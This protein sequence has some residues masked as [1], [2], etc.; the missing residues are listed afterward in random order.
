VIC[1]AEGRVVAESD[2]R[3]LSAEHFFKSRAEMNGAVRRPARS[4]RRTV[5]IAER[6]SFRPKTR[7]PILPALHRRRRIRRG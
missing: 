5:E 6:C 4:A 2:R 7:K 3:Q 1:I